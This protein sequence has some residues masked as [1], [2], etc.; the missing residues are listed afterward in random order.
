M[1]KFLRPV[2][3]GRAVGLS[4][5]MVRKYEESGFLPPAERSK[6]GYRI[7]RSQH[8]Y[9]LRVARD[10]IKGYGWTP[11]R[12]IMQA[13]HQGKES[14]ALAI[15]D[16]CHADIHSRRH[17]LKEALHSL[18]SLLQNETQSEWPAHD[19]RTGRELYIHEV[20]Q[21]VGVNTSAIRFWEERG[22]LQ[23]RR[24][25]A[26]RYRLYEREHIRQIQI[27]ALLRDAGYKSCIIQSILAEFAR[28]DSA[29][30][31]A[32]LRNL[33]QE[34]EQTSRLCAA[35]TAS[36]WTYYLKIQAGDF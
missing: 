35:A 20:A 25:T 3:L 23:P 34:L 2:D 36:F 17:R 22:L 16:K 31:G 30:M 6:S 4:A 27:I 32:A 8:L 5:Q 9:A 11:A 7:Y 33:L 10:L 26:S 19:L 15:I 24:D 14:E 28:E 18:N 21:L 13:V 1:S 29:S 12:K